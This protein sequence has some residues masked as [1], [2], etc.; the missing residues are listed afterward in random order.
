M[1][2]LRSRRKIPPQKPADTE[3]VMQ[4]PQVDAF[5]K[6]KRQFS[7]VPVQ[8]FFDPNLRI[9]IRTHSSSACWSGRND[10]AMCKRNVAS[11]FIYLIGKIRTRNPSVV[12]GSERFHEY[13]YGRA[14]V[15]QNDH[16]P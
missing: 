10:G 2:K 5:E 3:F 12:F 4:K 1:P 9:R 15:V 6:L 8:H 7:S 14:F 16:Q 11:R 13:L